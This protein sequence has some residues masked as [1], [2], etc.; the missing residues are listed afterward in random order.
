MSELCR[1]INCNKKPSFNFEFEKI[2]LFCKNHKFKNMV[3][4]LIIKKKKRPVP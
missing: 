3:K 2:P 1:K 4:V